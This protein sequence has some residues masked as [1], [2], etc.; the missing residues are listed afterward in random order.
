ML[1]TPDVIP[2]QTTAEAVK[3]ILHR[4]QEEGLIATTAEAVTRLEDDDTL[5]V[6]HLARVSRDIED[7]S[8]LGLMP[9]RVLKIGAGLAWLAYHQT[10]YI[11]TVNEDTFSVSEQLAQL[12]GIPEA[13]VS[14]LWQDAQLRHLLTRTEQAPDLPLA[15]VA[16]YQQLAD[17]G[18][19]CVRYYFQGALAAA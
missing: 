16:Q 13:Y 7:W 2:P 3:D 18:A 6:E 14:S 19:G 9:E 4:V 15:E 10:G 12:E 11:P 5:V 8:S 17:M 1:W